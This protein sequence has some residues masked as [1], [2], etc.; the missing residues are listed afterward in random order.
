[1]PVPII[2][3][4]QFNTL[5]TTAT[6]YSKLRKHFKKTLTLELEDWTTPGEILVENTE[7]Q[8]YS[9]GRK[10]C[11]TE[12]GDHSADDNGDSDELGGDRI[13][14]DDSDGPVGT[15]GFNLFFFFDNCNCSQSYKMA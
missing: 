6:F 10:C 7:W 12:A 13:K 2:S 5:V 14:F 3:D 11:R 4:A 15:I 1:M 8:S 9:S